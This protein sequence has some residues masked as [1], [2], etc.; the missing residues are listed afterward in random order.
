[1]L[2]SSTRQPLVPLMPPEEMDASFRTLHDAACARLGFERVHSLQAMAHGGDLAAAAREFLNTAWTLGSLD[3]RMRILIRLTVSSA[4]ECRYCT[5]HQIHLLVDRLKLPEALVTAVTSG[6]DDRLEG[7]ERAA[8]RFARSYTFSPGN[9]PADV[10]QDLKVHFSAREIVE[11]A[12]V[13]GAMA[14]LNGFNDGLAVPLE[15][16]AEEMTG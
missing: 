4:N 3:K 5:A 11:I 1:M 7:R 15:Q 12:V 13:A 16:D 8:V 6:D 2:P 9:I 14:M 10:T